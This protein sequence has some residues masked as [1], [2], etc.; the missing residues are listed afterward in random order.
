MTEQQSAL[1]AEVDGLLAAFSN[2]DALPV[3]FE[4]LARRQSDR[5]LA[6]WIRETADPHVAR[7]TLAGIRE[8]A[9]LGCLDVAERQ[10]ATFNTNRIHLGNILARDQAAREAM[11]A[12]KNRKAGS[13]P[14]RRQWADVLAC[15]LRG[16]TKEEKWLS[17]PESYHALQ[18]EEWG[19]DYV[20]WR[21]GDRVNCRLND[22]VDSEVSKRTFFETYL[23]KSEQRR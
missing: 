16:E 10:L 20:F 7:R 23:K 2:L 11:Q 1:I 19:D 9:A 14:K 15:L 4:K 21:D 8:Y 3:V 13:K 17:I 6:K 12:Q 18:H 22:E 5:V